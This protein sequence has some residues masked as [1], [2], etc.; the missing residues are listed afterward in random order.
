[1]NTLNLRLREHRH[2]NGM[3]LQE[4]AEATG[5]HFVTLWKIEQCR[6]K[7]PTEATLT[8]IGEALGVEPYLLAWE[9]RSQESAA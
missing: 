2:A 6:I 5:L 4:L 9:P 1:M 3:T 7:R 8:K